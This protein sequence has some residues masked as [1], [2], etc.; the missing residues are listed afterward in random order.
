MGKLK[1]SR[2]AP[3]LPNSPVVVAAH[4]GFGTDAAR[5]AKIEGQHPVACPYV[6]L[7]FALIQEEDVIMGDVILTEVGESPLGVPWQE[8]RG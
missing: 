2:G 1:H 8:Q 3:A 6:Q 5:G 7:L 4:R